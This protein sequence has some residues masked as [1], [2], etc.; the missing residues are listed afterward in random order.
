MP[1]RKRRKPQPKLK[2]PSAKAMRALVAAMEIYEDGDVALARQQLL[3]LVRKYP[4]SKPILLAILEVS[5]ETEDWY[6]LAYYSEKLVL[7]EQGEDQAETRNNLI[8]AYIQLMLPALAWQHAQLLINEASQTEFVEQ[9]KS[10]IE[11]IEPM[12]LQESDNILGETTFTK[13]EKI[14]LLALHDRVRFFTESGH[15]DEAIHAA[16]T[17]LDKYPNVVPILNNLSLSQ[18]MAGDLEQAIITAQNVLT[19]DPDNFHALGNLV[20][21]T[22]LTAQFDE[23]QTYAQHLQ[24]ITNDNLE[25]EVKQAEAFAFIGDD[26]QV[27]AAYERAKNKSKDLPP[28]LFHL[29]AAAAYRLGNEKSAWQLWRQAVKLQP[30]F[31]LAQEC[32][33]ER[34]LPVS[35]RDIPWY[36]SFPYWFPQDFGQLLE[37]YLGTNIQQ[38]S[39]KRVERGM[40]SLLAERPYLPKLFPHMFERGDRQ[41]REFALN[42]TRIVETPEL[43]QVS[44][45]FAQSPYGADALRM[46]AIQFISQHHP[47][48]LPENK[49]VP[50]WINGTQTE[51]F[52]LGFEI[53]D[54]PEGIDDIPDAILDKHET[55]YDFLMNDEPE[56]AEVLLQEII[57]EAP[58]FYPAYNQLA[59]AYSMQGRTEEAHVLIKETHER[60]PDYFF[61]RIA[62]ARIM[63]RDGQTEEAKELM[64]PLLGKPKLH[65]S[66]FRALAQAQMDIALAEDL[67]EAARTWLE[68]WEQIEEDHPDL[69]PWKMRIESP[70]LMQGLQNLM[71]RSQ[72]QKSS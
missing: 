17:L 3:Q 47:A 29:A 21:F 4:R 62:L 13:E 63:A 69:F 22:F 35:E 15:P 34:S 19:Q 39:E 26:A 54:E 72:K 24:Q 33:A 18:F 12:L 7:L 51:L 16:K 5:G 30:S 14:N 65:I 57:A 9:A 55:A 49:M 1:R 43:L 42:M 67:P 8:Y 37:K 48:M 66:E 40:K 52:M 56:K 68:M 41:T 50:M 31:E 23:A 28:L 20:R 10:L 6:T 36:W 60:F 45:D 32:L 27:W 25:L 44:Y 11:K 58:E 53:T 61:A 2:R 70:N 59:V 64:R 46:K 71:N 38:M